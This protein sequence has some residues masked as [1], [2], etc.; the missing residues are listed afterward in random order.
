MS[1]LARRLQVIIDVH[2]ANKAAL[3]RS[4]ANI[5]LGDDLPVRAGT[6]EA[7]TAMYQVALNALIRSLRGLLAEDAAEAEEEDDA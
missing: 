1:D 7:F 2:D 5:E 6:F 4:L 3:D